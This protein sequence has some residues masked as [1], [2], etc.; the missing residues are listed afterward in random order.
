[1]DALLHA[2]LNHLHHLV[3]YDT[4][5]PP[6]AITAD[7]IFAYLHDHLRD[8]R[9]ELSDH[10]DGALSLHAVRGKPRVLWNV[11]LDTVPNAPQWTNDPFTLSLDAHRVYGL[12][13]C[14]IKG[15]AAAL[16]AAVNA[17]DSDAALLFTCDEENNDARAVNSFVRRGVV[18]TA[19]IVA[20]PTQCQTVLAHRAICSLRV[21]FL[22]SAGHAAT[23][24]H[25][26]DSAVHKA[27]IWGAAALDQAARFASAEY[28]GLSGLR[29]N[30]GTMAGGI[31]GN[32]RAPSAEL[33]CSLRPLPSMDVAAVLHRL[34]ECTAARPE[35][36]E[37]IFEGPSLPAAGMDDGMRQRTAALKVATALQRPLGPA[38]DFWTE[39]AL[40]SAAGYPSV[41]FGPGDIQQAHSVDEFVA[42]SQLACYVKAV[43][44]MLTHNSHAAELF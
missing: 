3:A 26:G 42:I 8:F 35:T 16:L 7:G 32:V 28:E 19:V 11:H 27:L 30:I 38:V 6:R 9:C 5:N 21:G 12:G 43:Y 37:L 29:F 2:T 15:A 20:E 14:D 18:Y 22:G 17:C 36:F 40:F 1:M 25:T 41:V 24:H 4:R 33:R 39:A 23:G 10:G 34:A 13:V 44:R 31:K